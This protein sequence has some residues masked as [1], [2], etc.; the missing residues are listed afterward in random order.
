LTDDIG[1]LESYPGM[2]NN[3]G[4]AIMGMKRSKKTEAE[5]P[6]LFINDLKLRRNL[7]AFEVIENTLCG[8]D[9]QKEERRILQKLLWEALYWLPQGIA[10]DSA[11]TVMEESVPE[12]VLA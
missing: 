12:C 5:I 4:A 10:E 6:E 2:H 9:G 3:I 7:K 1:F 8:G 11:E